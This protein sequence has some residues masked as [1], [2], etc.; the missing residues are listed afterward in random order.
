MAVY[1]RVTDLIGHTPLLRLRGLEEACGLQAALYGKLEC[2]NPAGSAKDRAALFM[3][4]D[5]EARGL[6]RPGGVI[7]EPTSGNTGI[8][9]AFCAL[10]RG[11]RVI[12][13]MPETMSVER[14]SLLS[15]YGA[16]LILTPGGLGMQGAIDRAREIAASLPGAFVAGQFE[17]PA[18][19]RAHYE[20]TGP[21]IYED[22]DG[23]VGAFVACVGTGGTISGVGRYLKERDARTH[24]AAVEPARSPV[25]SGGSAGAHG[26]QGIGAGFVPKALCR[27]VLDEVIQ[28]TDEEAFRFARLAV[29]TDGVLCGISSGAVLAAAAK[30]AVRGAFQGKNVAVLLPDGGEKYL[31]TP[32]FA[33]EGT[34]ELP[35]SGKN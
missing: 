28:V 7:V 15:A 1:E 13:T 6:L 5:A 29:R 8:G 16:E 23:R 20:T 18:N 4:A 2:M 21:E 22:L 35:L 25:L 33:R 27:E 32:G 24:I 11:Y 34:I 26:I 14:R 10:Q 30:L 31:S 17:N 3:I 9:L 19:P 12:L